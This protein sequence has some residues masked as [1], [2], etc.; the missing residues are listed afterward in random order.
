MSRFFRHRLASSL[1]ARRVVV[2]LAAVG[3]VYLVSPPLVLTVL[4]AFR[5]PADALPFDSGTSWSLSN[6]ISLYTN[7]EI[8]STVLDTA[9]FA[10]GSVALAT[11][12]ALA[13]AYLIGRTD[14]PLRVPLLALLLLPVLMPTVVTTIAWVLVLGERTGA[15]NLAIRAVVP[16]WNSG[17]IDVFS[18]TGMII[19]Q[20]FSL[21]PLLVVFFIAA[22]RGIDRSL[23]EAAEAAGVSKA[24]VVTGITLPL[25][26]PHLLAGIIL[27]FIFAIEA[28]EVPLLLALGSDAD[29]LATRVYFALNDAT[30]GAP[31]Y[32]TVG[33]LGVHFLAI[34]YV[35]F[36]AYQRLARGEGR[37]AMN[38]RIPYKLD[39]L[40]KWR[41]PGFITIGAFVLLVSVVPLLVL[42]WT[43]LH[44]QYIAPSISAFAA[45]SL[46]QYASLLSDDRLFGALVNT[47]LVAVLAPALG[48]GT[49]LLL[50]VTTERRLASRLLSSSL[51]ALASSTIAIPSVIAANALLVFY[52]SVNRVIPSWIPLFGTVWLL[53]LAYAYRISVAYQLQ[54]A[55]V[56]QLDAELEEAAHVSG[57]GPWRT[58]TAI[59]AP[60]LR[61]NW[62]GAWILLGVFA[63]RELSLPL[64]INRGGPPHLVSTLVW[65]LWGSRTGEAAALG[66][67]STLVAFGGLSAG[68]WVLM[69][70][71]KG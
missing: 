15:L 23:E 12:L 11:F 46:D 62:I 27:A 48:V 51:S 14:L 56:A 4:S 28:F 52:L 68:W 43:S 47:I 55:G 49:A 60:L 8:L 33:V 64:V 20:G 67:L 16:L 25:I 9:L 22:L 44:P 37:F 6:F 38:K 45:V 58:L 18:M 71:K 36:F 24:R 32:G 2:T 34:T 41:W 42:L 70:R 39:S 63:F 5:A 3:T 30:G 26:R 50:A 66:F 1:T 35:L 54:R 53:V 10:A 40:G 7:G 29:I 31:R 59:T 57:A 65:E 13:L 19:V 21:V 17:P 69:V 61:A